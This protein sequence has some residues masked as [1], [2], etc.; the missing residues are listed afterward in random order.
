MPHICPYQFAHKYFKDAKYKAR[1]LKI[2]KQKY[3]VCK[4]L[5]MTYHETEFNIL[6][7]FVILFPMEP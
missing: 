2:S 5:G 4:F 3:V 7:F 1:Y 6:T